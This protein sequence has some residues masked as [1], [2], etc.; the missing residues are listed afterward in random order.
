[1]AKENNQIIE[2]DEDDVKS[3]IPSMNVN[4]P[5][6]KDEE[7]DNLISDDAMLGIYNEILDNIRKDRTEIDSVV[8]N[9]MDMV[10]NSGDTTTSSKE[11]L[12]NLLK[13]KSDQADKMSRV[14]DLMTRIKLKERDTFPRYLAA[15]QNNTIHIGDS[16]RSI[17]KALDQKSNQEDQKESK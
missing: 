15:H 1:M 10:I 3:M 8:S 7:K 5:V 12:V 2:T 17:L 9:F 16:K 11:A 13:L 4:V 14:A 6:Q